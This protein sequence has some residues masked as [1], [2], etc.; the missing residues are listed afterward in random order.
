ME[1]PL[2]QNVTEGLRIVVYNA[3]C[4]PSFLFNEEQ[5]R[6]CAFIPKTLT[7]QIK[8]VDVFVFC[9]IFDNTCKQIIIKEFEKLGYYFVSPTVGEKKR[10]SLC[11][12]RLVLVNGGVFIV[13]KL[14]LLV[15][16]EV[17]FEG[18]E[19]TGTDSLAAKRSPLYKNFKRKT[20]ISYFCYSFMRL[21]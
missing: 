18:S 8:Y 15:T 4:R 10:S 3:Y 1:Y 11:P 20:F 21:G 5:N 14:P 19:T 9:E 13:S 6:R 2:I 12:L 16:D 17:I 7:E